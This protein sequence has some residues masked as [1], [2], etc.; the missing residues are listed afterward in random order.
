MRHAKMCA[1]IAPQNREKPKV[2][3][4]K[5]KPAKSGT[6]E[7]AGPSEPRSRDS[8]GALSP[9]AVQAGSSEVGH[10]KLQDYPPLGEVQL[11]GVHSNARSLVRVPV[12]K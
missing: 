7:H 4:A 11:R 2:P 3:K 9:A 5:R 10:S 6:A 8:E 12:S 1:N